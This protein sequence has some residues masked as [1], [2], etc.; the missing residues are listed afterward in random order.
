MTEAT[1]ATWATQAVV[2]SRVDIR[3]YVQHFLSY[4]HACSFVA[5]YYCYKTVNDGYV[6]I[7]LEFIN[8]WERECLTTDYGFTDMG[9]LYMEKYFKALS[10]NCDE[11]SNLNSSNSNNNNNNNDSSDNRKCF[12]PPIQTKNAQPRIILEDVEYHFDQ[13]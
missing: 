7:E 4:S 8:E 6:G 12:S 11:I 9:Y 10:F 5:W 1:R 2:I 13:Q 3:A